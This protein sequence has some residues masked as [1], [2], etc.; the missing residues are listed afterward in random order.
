MFKKYI[1]IILIIFFWVWLISC[2][3]NQTKTIEKKVNQKQQNKT[4]IEI[5]DITN[6]K[7][8]KN[9][10]DKACKNYNEKCMRKIPNASKQLL[11]EAYQSCLNRCSNWWK[12]KS[13]C[14]SVALTCEEITD[15]CGL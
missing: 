8:E 9:F 12:I 6:L 7:Q 14:I 4:K 2:Q 10:C 5:V 15:N 13:E 11:E 3:K 1:L